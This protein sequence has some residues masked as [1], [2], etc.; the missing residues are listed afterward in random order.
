VDFILIKNNNMKKKKENKKIEQGMITLKKFNETIEMITEQ[1]NEVE[2][3][4]FNETGEVPEWFIKDNNIKTIS[5]EEFQKTDVYQE[6]KR[7][8]KEYKLR[9][10]KEG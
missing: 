10:N 8:E 3:K 6:H 1:L 4:K 2:L 7:L 9:T 5:E